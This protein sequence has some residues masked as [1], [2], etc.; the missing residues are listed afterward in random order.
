MDIQNF[1]DGL[2]ALFSAGSMEQVEPYFQENLRQAEE[3]SDIGAKITILNE[4]MGFYRETSQYEKAKESIRQVLELMEHSGLADSLPYATTLLNS[5]NAL[6]AAGELEQAAQYYNQ[7]FALFEGQVPQTD[8]RYAEL[9]NNV[10]LLYQEMKRYDMATQCLLN[11]LAIV[12]QIPGKEF[13]RAVTLANLGSSELQEGKEQE[14]VTHLKQAIELFQSMEVSDTHM[15]AALSAMG[16]ACFRQR[17]YHQAETYYEQAL[18][19]IE[20][21]VGR[22]E[23]YKRVE[24]SLEQV[25]ER[26]KAVQANPAE[27]QKG[28]NQVTK[29][30]AG[31]DIEWKAREHISGMELCRKFY[32]EA[33][34]SMIHQQFPAYEGR[35]AVGHVGEGSDRYGFDDELSEDHDF[36]FGFS[37]WLTDEDYEEIGEELQQAYEGLVKQY[38]KDTSNTI[39]TKHSQGRFGVQRIHTFYENLTRFP[40]GPIKQEDWV[41]VAEERL[42]AAVNGVVLR[43]DL[44][45]FSRIRNR[46]KNYYPL[47]IWLLKL[48]QYTS[49]FGQYGQYNYQRMAKRKDWVSAGLMRERA[50]EFALHSV[51]L[52]NLEFCPHDKW[53]RR[54]IKGFRFCERV[55]ELCEKLILTDIQRMEENM[56]IIEE[57]AAELL[58][59]M[60]VQGLVYP[61]KKGDILYL[62]NYGEELAEKAEFMEASVEELAEL[63]AKMEFKAFDQVKNEGGRAGC[64]DDWHTFR[65]MRVSQYLSWTKE[66]LLQYIMDFQGSYREGWN[67]ITEKYGRMMASTVPQEYAKLESNLPPVSEEKHKIVEEI[68]RIQVN[69]MEEF[70]KQYPKLAGNA[71]QIHT[72][73]DTEWDTSYETYL[74]GELLTYSDVMLVMYGR[75]ITL[76][77]QE[78]KNLAE[79]IMRNTVLLYG[80]EGLEAAEQ[81]LS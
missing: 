33:G 34:A 27:E 71:R 41:N 67:M 59:G 46:I 63:I 45:E 55:D 37:M 43:D 54:G 4:M 48:A 57:I 26:K 66:M 29:Q 75:F 15:A 78:K 61:R 42:S 11:A 14:A 9:Y 18:L 6:R 10:S 21:Y 13:Q 62:E 73:E 52:I 56:S 49:L 24:A 28:I 7:V 20:S 35:I 65:I 70:Q 22:T 69:W 76:R 32:E 64:Q 68:V 72:S 3:E 47:K 30:E 51:Y 19:M 2:D 40:E 53:L 44:G 74:R 16:E 79:E 31:Q 12:E 80:Y 23:A 81:A 39:W 25:R 58:E 38:E 77:V 36:G 8:F 5:A 50:A 17:D 1:F 60:I